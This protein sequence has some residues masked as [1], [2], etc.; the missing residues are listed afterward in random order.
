MCVEVMRR[1]GDLS[2]GHTKLEQIEEDTLSES[3]LGL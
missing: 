2:M 1:G 3:R